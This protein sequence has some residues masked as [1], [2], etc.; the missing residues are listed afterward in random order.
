MQKEMSYE[1]IVY[2]NLYAEQVIKQYQKCNNGMLP[3]DRNDAEWTLEEFNNGQHSFKSLY[4]LDI[5]DYK[6]VIIETIGFM[7]EMEWLYERI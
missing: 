2:C 3:L 1:E 4:H 6:D 7:V 5:D